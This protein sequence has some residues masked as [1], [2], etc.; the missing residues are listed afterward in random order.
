MNRPDTDPHQ[1]RHP[2][3]SAQHTYLAQK[4]QTSGSCRM[5]V[6]P[7]EPASVNIPRGA[8][9]G[10]APHPDVIAARLSWKARRSTGFGDCR[11]IDRMP[12]IREC[13]V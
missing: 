1:G 9:C 6:L 2:H 7:A 5:P 11:Q 4:S 10:E 3:L 13:G 8:R 12:H